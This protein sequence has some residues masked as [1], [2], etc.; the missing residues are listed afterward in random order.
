MWLH[1]IPPTI[2]ALKN[3]LS[4]ENGIVISERARYFDE[5]QQTEVVKM[6]DGF[7]YTIRE[8]KWVCLD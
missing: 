2:E 8:N 4:R 7:L 6:S 3:Y 5:N 1:E